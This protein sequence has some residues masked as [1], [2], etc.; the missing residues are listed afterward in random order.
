M[1]GRRA[2]CPCKWDFSP[3]F[4]ESPCQICSVVNARDDAEKR[5]KPQQCRK[6]ELSENC[7]HQLILVAG[8]RITSLSAFNPGF[9]ISA[10]CLGTIWLGT[11]G[12][13]VA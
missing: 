1:N 6:D 9:R 3:I 10:T 4:R 12:R 11:S 2:A 8:G 7:K 5:Y 13:A